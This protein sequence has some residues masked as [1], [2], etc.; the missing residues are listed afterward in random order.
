MAF[1]EFKKY[2]KLVGIKQQEMAKLIGYDQSN[3]SN[4]END[5]L[6]PRSV[7]DI[8]VNYAEVL[9]PKLDE[10]LK[11]VRDKFKAEEKQLLEAIESSNEL[12]NKYITEQLEAGKSK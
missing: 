7:V 3:F 2:R 10:K 12:Y 1:K 11:E 8:Y 9:M 4:I 5:R 6:R